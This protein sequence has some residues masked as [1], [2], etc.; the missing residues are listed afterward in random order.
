MAFSYPVFAVS[1]ELVPTTAPTKNPT[2]APTVA[3]TVS[4]T[5]APQSQSPT[6]TASPTWTPAPACP[7]EAN[8]DPYQFT[9]DEMY[10]VREVAGLKFRVD[11]HCVYE[12][13]HPED[14]TVF[15]ET[16]AEFMTGAAG[17]VGGWVVHNGATLTGGLPEEDD[18]PD[19][20]DCDGGSQKCVTLGGGSGYAIAQGGTPMTWSFHNQDD[21]ETF[22][23]F[24]V[25]FV[26]YGG[27]AWATWG[28]NRC[29][30]SPYCWDGRWSYYG[31][32]NARCSVEVR[33]CHFDFIA[34]SIDC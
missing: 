20:S 22:R 1:G 24:L 25:Q 28:Y 27:A 4:P 8:G 16:P 14:G 29:G 17:K 32:H 31:W 12:A 21:A 5:A 23:T 30:K 13:F 18:V 3:P 15:Y 19:V 9:N 11:Q 10:F 7:N 2:K 34:W 26:K 6:V 33:D